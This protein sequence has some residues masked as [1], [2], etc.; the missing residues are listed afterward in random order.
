MI[1]ESKGGPEN[2]YV[3]AGYDERFKFNSIFLFNTVKILIAA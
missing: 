3:E 2:P 1:R